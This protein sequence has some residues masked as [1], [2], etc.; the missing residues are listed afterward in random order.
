MK[1]IKP[2]I[3][4]LLIDDNPLKLGLVGLI[5]QKNLPMINVS[6]L[7][8]PP[9]WESYLPN[10]KFDAIVIDYRLPERNGLEE[11]KLLRRFSKD[12][13]VFLIT[14]L[15]RDEIDQDIIKAGATSLIVKDRNYSNLNTKLKIF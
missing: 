3:N 13:P 8:K 15:E 11:I 4:I 12:I 9:D 5:L 2:R 6:T 14:A 1:N 7:T 10:N